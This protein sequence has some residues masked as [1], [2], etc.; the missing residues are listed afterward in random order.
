M[1]IAT[2]SKKKVHFAEKESF[3]EALIEK[4]RRYEIYCLC[5][6]PNVSA[7]KIPCDNCLEWHILGCFALSST[8]KIDVDQ[9]KTCLPCRKAHLWT[10]LRASIKKRT[11]P[12]L[13]QLKNVASKL[14]I[15]TFGRQADLI[16]RLAVFLIESPT[17]RIKILT[18]GH[19]E[20]CRRRCRIGEISQLDTIKLI[21]Y[22]LLRVT[23]KECVGVAKGTKAQL[24]RVFH[25]FLT[26]CV[27][28]ADVTSVLTPNIYPMPEEEMGTKT[29]LQ[30]RAPLKTIS[31]AKSNQRASKIP[32]FDG[33]LKKG[34]PK[35]VSMVNRKVMKE[36]S[37]Q[38]MIKKDKDIENQK[39][40]QKQKLE[41]ES[42][43]QKLV[44]FTATQLKEECKQ[45]NLSAKGNKAQLIGRLAQH[46][47]N[48]TEEKFTKQQ[49]KVGQHNTPMRKQR[50]QKHSAD[51]DCDYCDLEFALLLSKL[52]V[53]DETLRDT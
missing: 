32:V 22:Q 10:K 11:V 33:S 14:G 12:S 44:M 8:Q 3:D 18:E 1:S 15:D 46:I 27:S 53:N 36:V 39:L 52:E 40:R 2:T 9:T 23:C 30:R 37:K 5:D 47:L 42:I 24:V 48:Q 7:P 35:S 6:L 21:N 38:E 28:P 20:P 4:T 34:K 31:T 43:K 41:L 13:E 45:S 16:V 25:Q 19:L 50:K 51:C 29:R 49:T 26:Q 17:N